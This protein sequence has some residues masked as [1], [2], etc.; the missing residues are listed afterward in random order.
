MLTAVEGVLL[1]LML[2][3]GVACSVSDIRRGIVRNSILLKTAMAAAI[4]QCVYCARFAQPH[5]LMWMGCMALADALAAL[6]YAAGLW[7]AGDAKLFMALYLCVPGRLLEGLGLSASV[8]PYLYI[9]IPAM[10]WLGVDTL[11]QATHRAE[12]HGSAR[13]KVSHLGE[14]VV[15]AL[16]TFA[17]QAVLGWVLPDF[18]AE[19]GLFCAALTLVYAL[20]CAQQSVMK[21]PVAVLLHMAGLLIATILGGW[22]G[23]VAPVWVYAVTLLVLAFT[24]WASLYNYRRIPTERVQAG[25]ILSAA[26]VFGFAPSRV[27]GLPDDASEGMA[28]RLTA[29]QANAVRRW[30][31]TA[32]GQPTVVIV[33]KMP[34]AILIGLGFALW[35]AMRLRG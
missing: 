11:W 32:K 10:I 18:F 22:R 24:R 33:R 6:M 31:N 3:T 17:V 28:A 9:F 5:A 29:D 30:A 1:A 4:V 19:N 35:M 12:R 7:A 20:L 13:F 34:F 26:T 8:V 2:A 14:M 21:S 15:V 25:M 16:E 27:R 23:G